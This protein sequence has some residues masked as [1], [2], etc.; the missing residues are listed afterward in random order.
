MGIKIV[1]MAS[2]ILLSACTTMQEGTKSLNNEKK[3]AVAYCLSKTYSDSQTSKDTG[4]ISGVYLQK[5][6]FG[7]DMYEEIR[8]FVSLYKEKP[9]NSKNE[10]NLDV[11]QCIDL[12]DSKAL[13]QIIKQKPDMQME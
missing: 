12:F 7:L 9:Y 6:D 10:R 1:C 4:Y 11:M 3:Y 13:N 2:F 5:G 8:A